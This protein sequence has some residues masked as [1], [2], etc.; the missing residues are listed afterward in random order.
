MAFICV[1]VVIY[2]IGYLA[3]RDTQIS[4]HRKELSKS[5][6]ELKKIEGQPESWLD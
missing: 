6:S 5:W 1:G 4:F 2:L 3:Y